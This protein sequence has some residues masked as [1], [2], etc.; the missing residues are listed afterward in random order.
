M[1]INQAAWLGW[2]LGPLLVHVGTTAGIYE[3]KAMNHL[4]L[5]CLRSSNC[6]GAI[7]AYG[8][9]PYAEYTMLEP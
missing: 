2:L 5:D 6:A 3:Q 8:K 7:A 4:M 9:A 1:N